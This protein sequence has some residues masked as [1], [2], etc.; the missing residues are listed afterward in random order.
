MRNSSK[1][2]ERG[3]KWFL[4]RWWYFLRYK[5]PSDLQYYWSR[6]NCNVIV[7]TELGFRKVHIHRSILDHDVLL[8]KWFLDVDINFED[9]LPGVLQYQVLELPQ[10]PR[11]PVVEAGARRGPGDQVT[12]PGVD[13][14]YGQ[15]R[16]VVTR[17]AELLYNPTEVRGP[18]RW[19]VGDGGLGYLIFYL[20]SPKRLIPQ[21]TKFSIREI[22]WI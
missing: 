8:G 22:E 5:V 9:V 15:P 7:R 4:W 2:R 13:L 20:F 10:L 12:D 6:W 3:T 17:P 19:E 14:L 21:T 16:L 18:E 1:L 11:A